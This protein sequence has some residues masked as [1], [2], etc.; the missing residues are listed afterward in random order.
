MRD[1]VKR[2][3]TPMIC[4]THERFR[5]N[6]GRFVSRSDATTAGPTS[7]AET[8]ISNEKKWQNRERYC[9]ESSSAIVD[10]NITVVQIT[11]GVQIS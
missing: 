4:P 5:N 2:M 6:N 8:E 9:M 11:S 3:E 7:G 1:L 10:N